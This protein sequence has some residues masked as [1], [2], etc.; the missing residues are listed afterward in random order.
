VDRLGKATGIAV[1][2]A[3]NTEFVSNYIFPVVLL[4]STKERRDRIREY[5]HAAGIQT[6]VH[7]PAAHKFSTYKELGAVLPQTEYA[8]DNEITLP[9]Y[10]AL[11]MDQIDFIV[12]TVEEALH[13]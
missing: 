5:M 12:K 10:A 7:Y 4:D 11:T 1:P 13:E 8:T 9:M 6:S 3:D 2:F